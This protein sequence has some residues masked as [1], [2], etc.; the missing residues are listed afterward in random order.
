MYAADL[1]G[2]GDLDVLSASLNDDKI[3]WYRN[4]GGGVFGS[5][6]VITTTAADGA[7]SV[8]AADLDGDGD[9]D[10]LSASLHDDNIAWYRNQGGGVFGSQ[11]VITTP[12]DFAFSV[13]RA[14]PTGTGI[15]TCLGVLR[16]TRSPGTRNQGGGVFGGQQVIGA[17]PPGAAAVYAAD[18]DGDG[19]E[20]VLSASH[21]QNDRLVPEPGRGVFSS[22]QVITTARRRCP[23]RCTR[24]TWTGTGIWMCSR[25]YDDDKI[26]WYRNQGGGVFGS[27]Q[28]ITTAANG[29]ASVYAVDLDGRGS[30]VLSASAFDDR[31]LGTGTRAGVFGSQQ[32]IATA[33]DAATSVYAAIWTGTGIETCSRPRPSTTRSPGTGT[34]QYQ[35]LRETVLNRP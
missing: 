10:V 31:S 22:Q 19:D 29:A 26:A 2:D 35:T 12:A 27:R 13:Y 1:D 28:V 34:L 16:D 4:Q 23:A 18:L 7:I 3:A 24:Q 30:D 17:E 33:A 11:Q 9:L 5:Q 20:H 8:Y 32:V 15:K 14:D 21:D 6:Q 25:R